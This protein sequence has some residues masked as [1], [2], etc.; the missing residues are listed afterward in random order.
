MISIPSLNRKERPQLSD[1]SGNANRKNYDYRDLLKKL[2]TILEICFLHEIGVPEQV[3]A[4]IATK[5]RFRY[6]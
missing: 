2:R 1:A 6:D 3:Y 4:V 5:H